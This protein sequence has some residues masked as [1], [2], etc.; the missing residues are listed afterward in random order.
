MR[1][2][3][4][5]EESHVVT[6]PSCHAQLTAGLR[7]CRMCGYRLGEGVEE[8]NETRR[9]D[10]VVPPPRAQAQVAD[11]FTPRP[12]DP[13]AAQAGWGASP[14]QPMMQPMQSETS[15]LGRI[16]GYCNP[17]RMG[18]L[19]WVVMA[20]VLLFAVGG[21]V[22]MIRGDRASTRAP[23][24]TVSLQ[25]EVDGFREV[26]GGIFIEGLDGPNTSLERAGLIGGDIITS[27]DGQPVGDRS[28]FLRILATTPP[29]KAVEVVFIRDGETK[30]TILTTDHER[31]YRGMRVMEG[32]AGG[33]GQI[34]VN[35]GD[36][37][38]VPD[39]NIHGVELDDVNRNG[40]ADLAGLKEGDL[41][42]EFN[43]KLVR[44]PGDLRLRI[45]EAE[46]GST[47]KAVVMRGKE[48]IEIPVKMGRS[49]G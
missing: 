20:M 17:N 44:T 25:K 39:S 49:R 26:D 30:A 33:R 36:R 23:R 10:G 37:V 3:E 4:P 13:F 1:H 46:P 40:P 7:F 43:E 9:F 38:R 27:F 15:S 12:S 45:Y 8:Y 16:A 31:D 22:K 35:L 41:V 47:V 34:G 29:G 2:Y 42:I 5:A 19:G 28:S 14:M 18:W 48:R 24:I 6:C 32:R 11:P 21:G